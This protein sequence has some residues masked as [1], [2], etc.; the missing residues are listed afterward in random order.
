MKKQRNVRT[1]NGHVQT[2]VNPPISRVD[3]P[4]RQLADFIIL[5]VPA[6]VL[7]A[8]LFEIAGPPDLL[9]LRC[10]AFFLACY[11]TWVLGN[12]YSV[13]SSLHHSKSRPFDTLLV[14]GMFVS[15]YQFSKTAPKLSSCVAWLIMFL[16]FL[17]LWEIYTLRAGSKYFNDEVSIPARS[18]HRREYRY[19]LLLD[20]LLLVVFAAAWL[21]REQIEA[22][23]GAIMIRSLGAYVGFLIGLV[24]VA[25]YRFLTVR[26]RKIAAEQLQVAAIPHS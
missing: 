23:F 22:T 4:D 19:W 20:G 21:V 3:V 12:E 13:F 18:P 16:F 17:V 7:I 2:T 25:R 8:L 26:I 6:A 5:G 1:S 9:V 10:Y 11:H 24:N 15:I 14:A